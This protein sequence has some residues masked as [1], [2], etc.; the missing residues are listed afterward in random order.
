M[1]CCLDLVVGLC[2]Q[3]WSSDDS[4]NSA[5]LGFIAR[6]YS[7][8]NSAV[9]ENLDKGRLRESRERER[10]CVGEKERL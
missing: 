2:L 1:C 9:E 3:D 7:G 8:V 6:Y 5:V 4:D 10:D